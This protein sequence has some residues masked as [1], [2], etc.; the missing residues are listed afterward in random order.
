MKRSLLAL[1]LV[2]SAADAYA[3]TPATPP[4]TVANVEVDPIRCWWRTGAG[5]VRVGELFDLTLTCA[6]LDNQDVQIVPDESHLG[7]AVVAMAPFEVVRGA[8]RSELR[9]GQRRFFQYQYTLRIINPDAIGKDV[10]VPDLIIH[11]KVNSRIAANTALEG[12]D[13]TYVLPPQTVRVTSMV[14]ADAVDIRDATGASFGVVDALSLRAGT[15]EIV[16]IASVAI[17]ALLT[18]VALV[19]LARRARKRV[20]SDERSLAPRTLVSAA[21][22]ELS[23][24]R[25]DRDRDGWSEALAGRALAATRI[26]AACAIG[27]P[28]SQHLDGTAAAGSGRV[29]ARAQ[30]RGKPH[31]LSSPV[32]TGDV[33][34][35]ADRQPD[36]QPVLGNLRDALAVFSETQ[37]G[38]QTALDQ[39]A[40]DSALEGAVA[41]AGRVKAEHSW[42]QTVLRQFLGGRAPAESRA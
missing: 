27:R 5:A 20:P 24:V 35:A 31:V 22:R 18:V 4:G 37:Y 40:L 16:A 6:L 14:P 23:A 17:G 38:R 29:V 9:A 21:M 34:R 39:S 42:L 1:L 33:A 25:R 19:R 41:A 26:A 28:V 13:L 32:T 2:T 7:G 10:R 36:R 12:R 8:P 3:Q 11:Y 30:W 15:L